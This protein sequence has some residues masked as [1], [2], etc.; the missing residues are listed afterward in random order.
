VSSYAPNYLWIHWHPPR[1]R[2]IGLSDVPIA[3]ILRKASVSIKGHSPLESADGRNSIKDEA[4]AVFPIHLP[5]S[6]QRWVDETDD[7]SPDLCQIRN[8]PVVIVLLILLIAIAAVI[9]IHL[10]TLCATL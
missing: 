1:I 5:G 10:W 9:C 3:G 6:S 7:G 4:H 2:A 8:T